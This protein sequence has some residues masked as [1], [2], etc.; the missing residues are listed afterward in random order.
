MT[1]NQF[2]EIRTERLLLRRLKSSDWKLISFLRTDKEVN[3]Y[4]KRPTAKTKEEAVTFISKID[5]GID[6]QNLFYWAITMIDTDQAIGTICLWN[7]SNDRKTAEIGFDLSPVFQGNGYMSES[8][9][10]TLNFGFQNL[11][12]DLISAYTNKENESSKKLLKRNAFERIENKKDEND[13][14]NVVYELNRAKPVANNV[15]SS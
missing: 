13:K 4:V 7:F 11:N 8:L 5:K 1:K 15:Y 10:S 9:K 2:K 12:L 14:D 6:Q 3:K